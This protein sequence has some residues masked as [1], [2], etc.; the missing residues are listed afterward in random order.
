MSN[1]AAAYLLAETISMTAFVILAIH[2]LGQ[3][4]ISNALWLVI[5][6]VLVT[7]A[8][9][10]TIARKERFTRIGLDIRQ[11]KSVVSIVSRTC[12]IVFPATFA[13]LWLLKSRGLE[14]PLRVAL[15]ENQQWPSW[16]LY[17][18]LYVAVA[19]E[20]FF[21]GYLQNNILRL[22]STVK[23]GRGLHTWASIVLSAVCFAA[24]H[25]LVRGQAV[26]ALTFLPGL[27]LG[28]LFVRT[29]SL[30]APILFHGLANTCYC[31]MAVTLV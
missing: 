1:R 18:F 12:I 8:V 19:E 29:R 26:S 30:L 28:W 7:A 3:S 15:P 9:V 10:P 17:Q 21:R 27:V 24:A 5:P 16:I 23:W 6:A 25:V 31:I 13:G 14:S 4:Y 2:L 22:T 20:V 11:I